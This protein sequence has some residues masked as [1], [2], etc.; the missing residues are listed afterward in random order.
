MRNRNLRLASIVGMVV[1]A[2]G[3]LEWIS[4]LQT[5]LCMSTEPI[6]LG[7]CSP[8]PNYIEIQGLGVACVFLFVASSVALAYSFV[9]SRPREAEAMRRHLVAAGI[10]SVIGCALVYLTSLPGYAPSGVAGSSQWGVPFQ[11]HSIGTGNGGLTIGEYR[12]VVP[13][14]LALDFVFWIVLS[15]VAI[16]AVLR[17]RRV[18]NRLAASG[19]ARS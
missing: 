12:Y 2:V 9:K 3:I 13:S 6:A 14:N 11:W 19:T 16:E 17:F 18:H 5:P 4:W 1:G 8:P 10:G 7:A 15:V